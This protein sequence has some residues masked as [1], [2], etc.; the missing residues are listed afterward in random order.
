MS[1]EIVEGTV[2]ERAWQ[3]I[4]DVRDACPRDPQDADTGDIV[5]ALQLAGLLV[6]VLR[7][8]AAPRTA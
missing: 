3:V 4:A 5:A 2:Y 7:D 6:P 1:T 8:S